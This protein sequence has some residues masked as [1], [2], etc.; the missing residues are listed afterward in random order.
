M[1]ALRSQQSPR[2]AL[3]CR[4]EKSVNHLNLE[5]N[6]LNNQVQQLNNRQEEIDESETKETISTESITGKLLGR[7]I[8]KGMLLL[9]PR[10]TQKIEQIDM[11]KIR[12]FLAKFK[13]NKLLS[14]KRDKK[15]GS[16][17]GC[18]QEEEERIMKLL[19]H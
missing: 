6:E 13:L 19:D 10:L 1:S 7:L 2:P 4:V 5:D 11:N 17:E 8:D 16:I 9:E 12:S 15:K 3:L 18:T 14:K